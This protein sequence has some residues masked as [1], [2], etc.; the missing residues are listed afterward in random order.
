MDAQHIRPFKDV[1]YTTRTRW[2]LYNGSSGRLKFQQVMKNGIRLSK[3]SKFY[4]NNGYIYEIENSICK[5][6]IDKM[7]YTYAAPKNK[8]NNSS[9][10]HYS[11]PVNLLKLFFNLTSVSSIKVSINCFT[12]SEDGSG[13]PCFLL[14]API[15]IHTG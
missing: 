8:Y 13:K 4:L 12:F 14:S 5:K 2:T 11:A 6:V 10:I 1:R 7:T 15:L 9:F 3:S